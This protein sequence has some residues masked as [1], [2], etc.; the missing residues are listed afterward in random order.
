L[1]DPT[2][3]FDFEIGKIVKHAPQ[4][5]SA[6]FNPRQKTSRACS[7]STAPKTKDITQI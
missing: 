3:P 6:Q 1:D 2:L 7:A 4:F 5:R